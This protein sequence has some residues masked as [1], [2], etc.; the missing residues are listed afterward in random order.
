MTHAQTLH[1]LMDYSDDIAF[2]S[3]ELK[4]YGRDFETSI[5]ILTS[6]HLKNILT[7]YLS[8]LLTNENL[9]N[10]AN[11]IEGREDIAYASGI[12]TQ[13]ERA[14]HQLANPL[15]TQPITHH[16]ATSIMKTL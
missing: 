15:L 14:I 5:A 11:A 10:W 6:S 12:E 4:Q 7:R 1:K 2:L 13:I 8:D 3:Q 16:T 9:E